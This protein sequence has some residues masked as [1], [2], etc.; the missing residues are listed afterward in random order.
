MTKR[1]IIAIA[2]LS[3]SFFVSLFC[4]SF[5][6]AEIE[7]TAEII[8]AYDD[9]FECAREILSRWHDSKR[10]FSL[11]LKHTDADSIERYYIELQLALEEGGREKIRDILQKLYAFLCVTAEGEK[12][13][14]ENIF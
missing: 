10:A 8:S 7:R 5:I 13:K 1:L 4:V 2:F 11:F 6:T 14:T 12:I 9:E 3:V